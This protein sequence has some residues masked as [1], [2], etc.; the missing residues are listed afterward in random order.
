MLAVILIFIFEAIGFLGFLYSLF[1]IFFPAYGPAE[2]LA[3]L[4]YFVFLGFSMIIIFV[5]SIAGIMRG[6]LGGKKHPEQKKYKIL[7]YTSYILL[8][9]AILT[10]FYFR[11]VPHL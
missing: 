2:G 1:V 6:I 9:T 11:P 8:T 5:S 10:F 3:Y 7:L 4:G